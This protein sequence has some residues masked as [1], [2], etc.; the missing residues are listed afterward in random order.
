LEGA[1]SSNNWARNNEDDCLL[2]ADCEGE[3]E[4]SVW[5]NFALC[6]FK[7]P[8]G[9]RASPPVLLDTVGDDS[10]AL[11]TVQEEGP[12]AYIPISHFIFH[13]NYL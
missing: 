5:S 13:I 4:V 8:S 1:A 12:S 2:W 6:F 9:T 3:A 7:L 11:P 10:A